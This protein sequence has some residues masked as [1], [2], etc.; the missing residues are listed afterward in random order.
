MFFTAPYLKQRVV[1]TSSFINDWEIAIFMAF[2]LQ[3]GKAS[4][5][6]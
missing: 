4:N 6:L 5:R 3:K 1:S 2:P